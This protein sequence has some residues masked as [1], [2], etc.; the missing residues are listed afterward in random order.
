VINSIP[1]VLKMIFLTMPRYDEGHDE[2]YHA[3][4]TV[5]E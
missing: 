5:A 2:L 3:S 4:A 1:T